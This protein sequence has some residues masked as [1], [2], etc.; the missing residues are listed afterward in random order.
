[1]TTLQDLTKESQDLAAELTTA[2]YFMMLCWSF[3]DTKLQWNCD[4]YK[5]RQPKGWHHY[6]PGVSIDINEAVLTGYNNAK[7]NN[8][9]G[10]KK[11]VY[12]D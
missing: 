5:P 3:E 7:N 4:F 2:G 10:S 8:I 1:M 6:E 11:T 9:W 12:E